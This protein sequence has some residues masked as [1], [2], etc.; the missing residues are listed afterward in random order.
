MNA[1]IEL[2]GFADPVGEAQATFRATLDAMARPGRLY[3]AGEHLTSP[4]PLDPATAAVLLTLV[5]NET[6]L[7][8]DAAAAAAHDWL[9]FHCGAQVVKTP[10]D[11]A[12]A[13]ALSLPD[14]ATLPAGSHE[15]PEDSATLIL[16]IRALGTG[17]RYRLSG[18]GLREPALLAA[19]GLP[20]DFAAIWQRNHA[21]YPRGV[22]IVL[23]SGTTLAALPRSVSIEEA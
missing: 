22:D 18:P 1:T 23:C 15:A 11:A 6:P 2:P 9:A 16:Q 13:V 21:L 19:D 20:A 10:T 12:F 8:L 4:A 5:D 7:W 14:L 17:V 3:R